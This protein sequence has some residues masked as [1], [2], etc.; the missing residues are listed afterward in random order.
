MILVALF[1]ALTAIG[2]FIKIYNPFNPLVPFTLQFLFCA[3]AGVLLGTRLG[4][5]SQILYV[6]VGLLGIPVFTKGGGFGYIFEPTFGYLLGFI[7]CALIIGKLTEKLEKVTFIRIFIPVIIGLLIVYGL[8][9]PYLYMIVKHYFGK[10]TFTF[11]A[12]LAAG[13]IPYIL[14]DIV[15]SILISITAVKIIPILRRT[16]YV[17]RIRR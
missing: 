11:S 7:F 13:F 1:A 8:G 3:Y 14:P 16:G 12:A 2:A 6:G 17:G 9:V 15:L 10:A 4:F 5:Y